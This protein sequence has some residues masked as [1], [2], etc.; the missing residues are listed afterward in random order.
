MTAR[1]EG[2]DVAAM[3]TL[4][5]WHECGEHGLREDPATAYRWFKKGADLD[6][7]SC[8]A[9]AGLSLVVGLGTERNVVLGTSMVSMAAAWGSKRAAFNLGQWFHYGNHG[10][11]F[12]MERARHW[13]QKVETNKV[14]DIAD[15]FDSIFV[16]AADRAQYITDELIEEAAERAREE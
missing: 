5:S 9:D 6:D 12:D 10:I 1:A 11:P 16:E 14:D 3:L 13:Y 7:P 15:R 4:G 2:G 8:L